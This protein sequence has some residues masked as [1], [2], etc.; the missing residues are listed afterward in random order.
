MPVITAGAMRF[1]TSWNAAETDKITDDEQ[2]NVKA[3]LDA[4]FEDGVNHFE[5][6]RGYGTSEYQVGQAIADMPRKEILLQTKIGPAESEAEFLGWFEESLDR[7]GTDYVDLLSVHGINNG[8]LLSKTLKQGT[9]DACRKLKD[10][11]RARHIGFSSHGSAETIIKAI[12]TRKFE[13]VNLHWFYVDQS[14][15]AAMEVAQGHDMGVF[16]ISPNDKGGK[17]YDPP[18]KLVDLCHPLAPMVFNDLYCLLQPE[19]HTLSIGAKEPGD[20]GS[21]TTAAR[22]LNDSD[23]PELVKSIFDRLEDEAVAV[24]GE[25][26]WYNWPMGLPLW[27]ET[28][29]EVNIPEI[30]R[31][32]NLAKAF[33]M[34]EYGKMRY[35]LL[36][37]GGHWF[38]GQQAGEL[39]SLDLAPVL[40]ESPF[41]EHIPTILAEAHEMFKGEDVE[42]LQKD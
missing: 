27:N 18:E 3:C 10:E 4:A 29:G 31:L 32:W 35:N 13:Y 9:M 12:E 25:D 7:L 23:T 40:D 37:N 5:T 39:E 28:P 36:G 22:M 8:E 20:F 11:G 19:I 42:R 2:A 6:A 38:P 15:F 41:A 34:V 17:L 21:H 14:K 26:W 30:V 1:Q 24:L 16:I 33:D